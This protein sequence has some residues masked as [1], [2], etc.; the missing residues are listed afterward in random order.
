[1]GGNA[2]ARAATQARRVIIYAKC[3]QSGKGARDRPRNEASPQTAERVCAGVTVEQPAT[4]GAKEPAAR[5]AH[6]VKA[7]VVRR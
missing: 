5:I 2:D 7:W 3:D 4:D 6:V 1:M